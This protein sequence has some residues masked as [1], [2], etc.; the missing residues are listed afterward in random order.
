MGTAGHFP[1]SHSVHQ[2]HKEQRNGVFPPFCASCLGQSQACLL[3]PCSSLMGFPGAGSG[4]GSGG[5]SEVLADP[6]TNNRDK[7]NLSV[8]LHMLE[9]TK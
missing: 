1:P 5:V 9:G 8:Q 3:T 7:A 2:P 4:G 6:V